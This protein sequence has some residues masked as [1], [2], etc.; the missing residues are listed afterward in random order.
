MAPGSLSLSAKLALAA[1]ALSLVETAV[2]ALTS[3]AWVRQLRLVMGGFACSFCLLGLF[4]SL[5]GGLAGKVLL[6]SSGVY[7]LVFSLVTFLISY[8]YFPAALLLLGACLVRPKLAHPAAHPTPA[9]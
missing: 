6:W 1:L 2:F 9:R 8:Y 7:Y 3:D 4:G 5:R